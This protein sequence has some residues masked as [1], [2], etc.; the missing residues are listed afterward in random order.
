[1]SLNDHTRTL[2][3]GSGKPIRELATLA[4]SSDSWVKMYLAG[5]VKSPNV[6]FVQRLYEGLTGRKLLADVEPMNADQSS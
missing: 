3:R 2:A 5:Y 1:M 4:G 6:D